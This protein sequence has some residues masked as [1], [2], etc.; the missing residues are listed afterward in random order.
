MNFEFD[1]DNFE[2]SED[3]FRDVMPN[4][5]PLLFLQKFRFCGEGDCPDWVLAEI[6]ST[7]SVLNSTKV[8]I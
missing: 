3:Y 2:Y 1:D 4:I 8:C 5:F 6:H 7:L